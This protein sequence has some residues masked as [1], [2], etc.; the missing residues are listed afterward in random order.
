V[1]TPEYTKDPQGVEFQ[2]SANHLGH[3]LL[4][5]LIMPNL[6]AAGDARVVNI[7]SQGYRASPFHFDDWNFSDGKTYGMSLPNGPCCRVGLGANG[8]PL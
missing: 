7:S 5:N 1:A 8:M 6:A 3:F 2:L 4:T